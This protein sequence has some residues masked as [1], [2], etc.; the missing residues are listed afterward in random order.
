M[1]DLNVS[2]NPESLDEKG[3]AILDQFKIIEDSIKEI[4]D[5]KAQLASWQ[6]QNKDKYEAKI[7]AALPK[8]HEMSEAISS[9]GSVAR[10]TSRAIVN[11]EN[12]ISRAIDA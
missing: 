8:M 12:K 11:T 3:K 9:Y 10:I 5:S 6:S 1:N 4:E 7:N 2:I